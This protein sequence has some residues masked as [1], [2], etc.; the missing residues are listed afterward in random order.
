MD[1]KLF[2]N[3]LLFFDTKRKVW[4]RLETQRQLTDSGK[5]PNLPRSEEMD[6]PGT[7]SNKIFNA[8]SSLAVP[9]YL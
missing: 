3:S 9:K 2:D 4:K 7:N 5:D 1:V 8:S 6:P